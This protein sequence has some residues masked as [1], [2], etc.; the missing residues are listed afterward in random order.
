MRA[1]MEHFG[2]VEKQVAIL[3]FG[4]HTDT[5][6]DNPDYAWFG[7]TPEQQA[8]YLVRAFEYARENWSPWIGPMF[9]WNVPDSNWTPD[10]EEFWWG[11]VDPFGWGK[12]AESDTWA[13]GALRPAYTAL[14]QMEKSSR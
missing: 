13:G 6:P 11:I 2:D 8:D 7:V 14:A 9:V 3:E 5:R 10:N 12:D 1:V 4:W